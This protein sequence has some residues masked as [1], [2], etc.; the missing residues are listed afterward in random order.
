MREYYFR[1]ME[2]AL[3][4]YSDDYIT[5]YFDRV[6]REGL[7]EHGFPRLTANIGVLIAHGV[8]TDLLPVF[9]EVIQYSD[10]LLQFH[11]H[12]LFCDDHIF[13]FTAADFPFSDFQT[14]RLLQSLI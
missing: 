10:D 6:K 4:A 5:G 7:T 11:V 8:R 9:M 3:Q 13:L 2:K 12:L 14:R 1:L